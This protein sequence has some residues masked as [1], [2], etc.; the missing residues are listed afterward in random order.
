MPGPL[1][2]SFLCLKC[3]Q[4]SLLTT[5]SLS[6]SSE[7]KRFPHPVTR[8]C[9]SRRNRQAGP[10]SSSSVYLLSCLTF[11]ALRCFR[12]VPLSFCTAVHRKRQRPA[13]LFHKRGRPESD[14]QELRT[15]RKLTKPQCTNLVVCSQGGSALLFTAS[16]LPSGMLFCQR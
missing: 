13:S 15:P 2:S 8:S 3:L 16:Q 14:E 7:I 9:G 6:V 10:V 1:Q 4:R 11:V 5:P 12:S